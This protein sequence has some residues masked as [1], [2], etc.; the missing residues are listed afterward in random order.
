MVTSVSS[1]ISNAWYKSGFTPADVSVD[2]SSITIGLRE[3]VRVMK[4]ANLDGDTQPFETHT[5]IPMVA[6]QE[7]YDIPGLNAITSLS[8]ND[9]NLRYSLQSVS[10]DEYFSPS[11]LDNT[12]T[13]PYMYHAEKMRPEVKAG[14]QQAGGMRL[15]IYFI[16]NK[17]YTL[18][19]VGKFSDSDITLNTDLEQTYDMWMIDYFELSLAKRI[20]QYYSMSCPQSMLDDLATLEQ[21]I[22]ELSFQPK[23]KKKQF[24]GNGMTAL[25][26]QIYAFRWGG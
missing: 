15:Y 10:A 6:G 19:I 18:N 1:V 21:Q 26:A 16:P 13:L 8:Y 2:G 12:S 14:V 25:D 22:K 11:R 24:F 23:M 9:G 3:L 17:A 20:C 4:S 5:T 7:S